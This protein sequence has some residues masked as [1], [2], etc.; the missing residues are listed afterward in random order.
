MQ[1]QTTLLPE[2]REQRSSTSSALVAALRRLTVTPV[3]RAAPPGPTN[4]LET[5][6]CDFCGRTIP[7]DHRHFADLAAMKFMCACETCAVLQAERAVFKPLPQRAEFL[8]SFQLPEPLWREFGLPVEMAFF[9]FSSAR[10][11]VVAFYPAPTGATESQL[12]TDAWRQLQQL[13]P[14]LKDLTPDLEALLVN[15]TRTPS[16]YYRAP[17]DL[18][19]RLIGLMRLHWKGLA[20]GPEVFGVLDQFFAELKERS[21]CLT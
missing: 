9:V 14:A 21:S 20:G 4:A 7:P 18:C 16:E 3:P 5:E 1:T 2:E 11:R 6:R 17:I 12:E 19:Y 10:R 8:A 15:R 13:N